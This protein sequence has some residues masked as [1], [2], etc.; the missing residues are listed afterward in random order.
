MESEEEKE[1]TEVLEI[2]PPIEN[3]NDAAL[4][5]E[6]CPEEEDE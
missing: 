6:P 3:F 2:V 4:E 5:F 1:V